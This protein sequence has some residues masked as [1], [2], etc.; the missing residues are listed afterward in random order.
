MWVHIGVKGAAKSHRCFC[1]TPVASQRTQHISKYCIN[2]AKAPPKDASPPQRPPKQRCHTAAP[3]GG[4]Q[5]LVR[6]YPSNQALLL[7]PPT[8]ISQPYCPPS[9]HGDTAKH[10]RYQPC[11]Q[12][13]EQ[14]ESISR[15][16]GFISFIFKT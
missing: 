12:V 10:E 4:H 14:R 16:G 5:L 7:P 13:C 1:T 11:R 8:A 15:N 3:Y 2:R 9:A 6:R